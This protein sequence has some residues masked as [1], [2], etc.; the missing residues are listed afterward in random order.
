MGWGSLSTE[1]A[2]PAPDP[3]SPPPPPRR[4][5]VLGAP[6]PVTQELFAQ[7]EAILSAC[8]PASESIDVELVTST[9]QPQDLDLAD[10]LYLRSDA[11]G[12][13]LM[14]AAFDPPEAPHLAMALLAR[15]DASWRHLPSLSVEMALQHP[16][17][18]AATLS[19][20]L[21][22]SFGEK[23]LLQ[24]EAGFLAMAGDAAA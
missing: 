17:Y 10:A 16:P 6:H 18:L 21:G 4:L 14:T 5:A 11:A 1:S 7:I 12:A 13:L 24:A 15:L 20:R 8:E 19:R 9:A 3:A 2:N 23:A 22:L